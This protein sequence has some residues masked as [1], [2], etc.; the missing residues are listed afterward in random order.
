[1]VQGHLHRRRPQSI[2][3]YASA[4]QAGGVGD[5]IPVRNTESGITVSG[6][7]QIDGTVRV[8]NG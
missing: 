1:M 2:S 8:G 3:T 4:L 5:V 6:T 7:V